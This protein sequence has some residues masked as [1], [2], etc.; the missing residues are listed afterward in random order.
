[1]SFVFNVITFVCQVSYAAD[2]GIKPEKAS[3]LI[4]ILG[5]STA[6]GR[7]IFGKIIQYG[8]LDRVRM[9]QLSMVITGAGT[10]FLP[11]I[12]SFAGIATYI[13][14]VGL[15]D[16]CYIVL[17]PLLTCSLMGSEKMVLAWGF[18]IGTASFT[19]TMG[20]PVAG[21]NYII[22]IGF[23]MGLFYFK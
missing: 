5:I 9:H 7:I 18:L 17:L 11:L 3:F 21:V 12:R 20:P 19:F 23:V 10:M 1:M 22:I 16:G 15:V 6:F 4:M 14:I 8:L 13:V 2:C